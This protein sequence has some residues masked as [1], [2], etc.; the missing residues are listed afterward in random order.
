[1]L[2]A[3][4]PHYLSR[5]GR[6]QVPTREMSR[7]PLS[8]DSQRQPAT[9]A[10]KSGGD[11]VPQKAGWERIGPIPSEPGRLGRSTRKPGIAVAAQRE[12][13]ADPPT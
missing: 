2:P 8:P 6:G 3:V 5:T 4:R 9:A 1:M 12:G 11:T 7:S 10:V 13:A